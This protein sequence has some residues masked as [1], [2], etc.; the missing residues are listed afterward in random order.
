MTKRSQSARG[1]ELPLAPILL[2]MS[3]AAVTFWAT[4]NGLSV[5]AHHNAPLLATFLAI[6]TIAYANLI[7][8]SMWQPFGLQLIHWIYVYTFFFIAPVA[9]YGTGE[10]PWGLNTNLDER[11]LPTNYLVLLW[12]SIWT[13]VAQPESRAQRRARREAAVR[14][15]SLAPRGTAHKH[16]G[17]GRTASERGLTDAAEHAISTPPWQAAVDWKRFRGVRI[18]L[19]FATLLFLAQQVATRGVAGLFLR[20]AADDEATIEVSSI[21][22]LVNYAGRSMPVILL[23]MTVMQRRA[24]GKSLRAASV[25]WAGLLVLIANFPLSTARF[26]IA[27]VAI[28]TLATLGVLRHR[29]AL[30]SAIFLG[31]GI[32]MPV[33]G[34]ARHATDGSEFVTAL[35]SGENAA[36]LTPDFDAYSVLTFTHEYVSTFGASNGFQMLTAVLFFI[37]RA[38]WPEKSVGSGYLV[39]HATNM[40]FD[41][42]SNTLPAEGIINFGVPG[43]IVFAVVSALVCTLFDRA[44]WNNRL[45]LKAQVIFPFLLG[46][47]FFMM[48]GDMLSSMGYTVGMVVPFTLV[49]MAAA[50]RRV[51]AGSITPEAEARAENARARRR[52]TARQR[53]RTRRQR[54]NAATQATL[55]ARPARPAGSTKRLPSAAARARTEA[56]RAAVEN[57]RRV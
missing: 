11:L 20:G 10:L 40:P 24:E 35:T 48:R 4:A 27:L 26:W 12:V 41:N 33:L 18:F 19:V 16:R 8:F 36:W 44:Y 7:R 6:G 43:L 22:L 31:L 55:P 53:A 17:S 47:F 46:A 5:L 54:A 56:A 39:A 32:L 28:G 1:A 14:R 3:I 45:G 2:S 21:G 37:P 30:T 52:R 25:Y 15:P 38:I 42:I 9:Q 57:S 23:V 49:L 13:L 29:W 51:P 34:A 50:G